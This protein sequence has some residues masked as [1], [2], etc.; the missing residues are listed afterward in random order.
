MLIGRKKSLSASIVQIIVGLEK[1]PFIIHKELLCDSS[2]FF[3]AALKGNFKEATDQKI[4]LLD[5][6]IATFEHFQI[7]L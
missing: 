4:E 2:L 3:S 6:D 1:Q 5:G 7:W